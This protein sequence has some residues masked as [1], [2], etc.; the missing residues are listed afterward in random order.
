MPRA[1]N[2]GAGSAEV[3]PALLK[4]DADVQEAKDT[5]YVHCTTASHQLYRLALLNSSNHMSSG[6]QSD[7]TEGDRKIWDV[8]WKDIFTYLIGKCLH[9]ANKKGSDKQITRH[10]IYQPSRTSKKVT[11]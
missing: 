7:Q 10:D 11:Y 6:Q 5:S 9:E 4:I 8:I 2:Y 1:G 3:A